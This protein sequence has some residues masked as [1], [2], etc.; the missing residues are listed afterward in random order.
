M[1]IVQEKMLKDHCI[2]H[3]KI[4]RMQKR[5]T[6]NEQTRKKGRKN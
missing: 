6:K 2:I 5:E 4:E 3:E 1:T